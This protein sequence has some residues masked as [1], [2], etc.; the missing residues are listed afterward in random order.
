MSKSRKRR[1]II[2]PKIKMR[3]TALEESRSAERD[4]KRKAKLAKAKEDKAF[5]IA[6]EKERIHKELLDWLR[7]EKRKVMDFYYPIQQDL[8]KSFKEGAIPE[9]AYQRRLKRLRNNMRRDLLLLDNQFEKLALKEHNAIK[10]KH[11]SRLEKEQARIERMRQK[12]ENFDQVTAEMK[13]KIKS[14]LIQW[15]FDKVRYL[16]HSDIKI[17]HETVIANSPNPNATPLAYGAGAAGAIAGKAIVLLMM[18]IQKGMQYWLHKVAPNSYPKPTFTAKDAGYLALDIVMLGLTI[19]AFAAGGI[20]GA[21]IALAAGVTSMGVAVL[22]MAKLA[23]KSHHAKK[24]DAQLSALKQKMDSDPDYALRKNDIDLLN[25]LGRSRKLSEPFK[26]QEG[27]TTRGDVDKFVNNRAKYYAEKIKTTAK[28]TYLK[29]RQ[30]LGFGLT[31]MSI[32][33]A[34]L[35]LGGLVLGP[36]GAPVVMAGVALAIATSAIAGGMFIANMI[37]NARENKKSKMAKKKS[38]VEGKHFKLDNDKLELLQQLDL[39]KPKANENAVMQVYQPKG[40]SINSKTLAKLQAMDR[41]N[42]SGNERD[43]S[44]GHS[45]YSV[46]MHQK[47]SSFTATS[48]WSHSDR[49]RARISDADIEMDDLSPDSVSKNKPK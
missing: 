1:K 48:H 42:A 15:I 17:F 31:C 29:V 47:E 14:A 7:V 35:I 8:E 21:A 41:T 12:R 43:A 24:N 45:P 27:V 25:K 18:P 30:T 2:E 49:K 46:N 16:A 4:R 23:Y 28:N 26:F 13:L 33:S 5:K 38:I 11:L 10:N 22:H 32:A 34:G 6:Q 36:V 40:F 9:E 39:A 37:K 3:R 44:K 19:A 20:P